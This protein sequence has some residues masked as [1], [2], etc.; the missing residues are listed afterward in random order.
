MNK[1]VEGIMN[2]LARQYEL[3]PPKK[4]PRSQTQENLP[5]KRNAEKK[6]LSQSAVNDISVSNS[7]EEEEAKESDSDA[8]IKEFTGRESVLSSEKKSEA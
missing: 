2:E 4:P 6:P 1:Q 8:K 3:L 5:P 7:A